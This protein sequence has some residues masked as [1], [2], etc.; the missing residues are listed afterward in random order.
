[1]QPLR[2]QAGIERQVSRAGV[3]HP[4]RA[5]H[6]LPAFL[7]HEC[8]QLAGLH[9]APPQQGADVQRTLP[10]FGVR[11]ATGGR[12]D[13]GAR[14]GFQSLKV[15]QLVQQQRRDRCRGGVDLLHQRPMTGRQQVERGLGPDRGAVGARGLV[16][17]AGQQ[18]TVGREHRIEQP[19]REEVVDRIPVE[20]QFATGLQHLV[21]EPDLWRLRDADV[22]EGFFQRCGK[23]AAGVGVGGRHALD[24]RI[25]SDRAGEDHRHVHRAGRAALCAEFTQHPH[26]ADHG[27]L[28]VAPELRL[29]R[30]RTLL[31]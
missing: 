17:Q 4:Q 30:P 11:Q 6:L 28:D 1:M 7:Q 26:A 23:E 24:A 8:H 12:R 31:E 16:A 15:E 5:G 19:G 3:H 20:D 2:R 21:V 29:Q 14:R 27:V 18:V 13:G 10:Q 25:V 9:T 22:L